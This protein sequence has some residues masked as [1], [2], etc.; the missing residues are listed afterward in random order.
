MSNPEPAAR[1][2]AVNGLLAIQKLE[3]AATISI[4]IGMDADQF[5]A[6]ALS[7]YQRS[8]SELTALEKRLTDATAAE[9]KP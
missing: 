1:I 5:L 6:A 8:A 4:Y 9:P 2:V 7:A 3:A